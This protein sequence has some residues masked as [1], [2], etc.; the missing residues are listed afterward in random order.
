[1]KSNVWHIEH[2]HYILSACALSA[3]YPDMHLLILCLNGPKDEELAF[4]WDS[5]SH[6]WSQL[7]MWKSSFLEWGKI[8]L[9]LQLLCA[10][11]YMISARGKERNWAYSNTI[12]LQK[13]LGDI[14]IRNGFIIESHRISCQKIIMLNQ[15]NI[16]R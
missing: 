8:S 15:Q 12:C 10:S 11:L 7:W 3:D 13:L 9:Q 5:L 6:F 1:M 14:G 2:A 16:L 4:L